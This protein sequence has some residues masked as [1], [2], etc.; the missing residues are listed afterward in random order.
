MCVIATLVFGLGYTAIFLL[1]VNPNMAMVSQPVCPERYFRLPLDGKRCVTESGGN[2]IKTG[3]SQPLCTW[4][5]LRNDSCD[6]IN[7]KTTGICLLGSGP[8]IVT[9]KEDQSIA[10]IFSMNRP[11][12]EWVTYSGGATEN[13]VRLENPASSDGIYLSV[14]RFID[15]DNKVPGPFSSATNTVNL[16]Y[17]GVIK[18]CWSA[19]DCEELVLNPG[20]SVDWVDYKPETGMPLPL[21]VVPGGSLD[22]KTLYIARYFDSVASVGLVFSIGYIDST[23]TT[24]T[25]IFNSMRISE[26]T[27]MK[28][29]VWQ[30]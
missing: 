20:C 12:L 9:E 23:S 16:I 27:E 19:S 14:V 30:A 1:M 24:A 22:G 11:C 25:I 2:I 10:T 26:A 17:K 18:S 6:F 13:S 7:F 29:L 21:G 4:H 28:L 15:G 5:C 8:C 3:I